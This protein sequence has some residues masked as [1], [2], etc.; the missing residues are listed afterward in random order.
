MND[1]RH[2]L[3]LDDDPSDAFLLKR[4]LSRRLNGGEVYYLAENKEQYLDVLQK[5]QLDVIISDSSVLGLSVPEA[6]SLAQARHAKAV[7]FIFSGSIK[8]EL[9]TLAEKLGIKASIE[10]HRM[11]DLVESVAEVLERRI[12]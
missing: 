10:K 1:Q 12:P 8:A 5:R 4:A 9:A 11:D 7:F 3:I 2:I 6:F